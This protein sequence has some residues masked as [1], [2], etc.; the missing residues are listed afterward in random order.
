MR[1][2]D[3]P[4]KWQKF[5]TLGTPNA[6]KYV[7]QQGCSF[8]ADRNAKWFSHVERQPGNFLQN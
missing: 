6:G 7:E 2:H 8:I 1:C 3:T 4:V 5:K